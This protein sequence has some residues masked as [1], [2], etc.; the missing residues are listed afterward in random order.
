MTIYHSDDVIGNDHYSTDLV[1][2]EADF[3]C[4]NRF[5]VRAKDADYITW[6]CP[7]HYHL[8][9]WAND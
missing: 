1:F 5:K 2:C 7:E 9:P 8:A 3:Q 4:P 6:Y